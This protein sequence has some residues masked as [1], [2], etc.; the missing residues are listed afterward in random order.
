[1]FNCEAQLEGRDVVFQPV[2]ENTGVDG[3]EYY[4][5]SFARQT[6]TAPTWY[7]PIGGLPFSA[8]K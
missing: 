2:S 3:S 8:L 6:G 1:M 5:L 7:Q 4:L